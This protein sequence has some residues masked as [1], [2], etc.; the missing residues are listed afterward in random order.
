MRKYTVQR[1][2]EQKFQKCGALSRYEIIRS[3]ILTHLQKFRLKTTNAHKS[4]RNLVFPSLLQLSDKRY[5]LLMF[6]L[7][8]FFMTTCI[9]N[10]KSFVHE[11]SWITM[12]TK[13]MLNLSHCFF[14]LS[15]STHKY[16]GWFIHF[17]TLQIV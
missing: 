3:R 14:K 10:Y 12:I 17:W 1:I 6:H 8:L 11:L 2:W 13:W 7:Y 15:K 16:T 5:L 9:L 4:A